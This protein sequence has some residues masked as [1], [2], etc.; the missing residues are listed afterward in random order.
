MAKIKYTIET[1]WSHQGYSDEIEIDDEE[2]EGLSAAERE[3]HIGAVVAECVNNVV[4]W[5]WDEQE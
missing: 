2:L 5:G 1:S 3:K 4:S